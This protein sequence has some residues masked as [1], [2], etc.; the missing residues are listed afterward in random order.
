MKRNKKRI[1]AAVAVICALAA[2][3]A[4]F[5]YTNT[6]PSDTVAG[7]NHLSVSGA[8]VSALSN[9]L[10]TDG[11]TITAVHLAFSPDIDPAA[12]VEIGWG[13]TAGTAPTS[14]SSAGCTVAVDGSS[15]DCINLTQPTTTAN[16]FA[17]A[18]YK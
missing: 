11:Q 16:D 3:G 1:I 14:L 12:T 15:A 5:T 8:D 4:A 2:G 17:V 7:Y 6:L 9:T 18:V 10:S 13:G